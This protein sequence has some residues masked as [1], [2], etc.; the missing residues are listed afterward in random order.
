[1]ANSIKNQ[2]H[3]CSRRERLAFGFGGK[4][5]NQEAEEINHRDDAYGQTKTAQSGDQV[6]GHKRTHGSQQAT[7]VEAEPGAGCAN[8]GGIQ[9][10]QVNRETAENAVVEKS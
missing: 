4:W 6:T 8:P 9:F 3:S 5:Q 10:R 1:M 7:D 2:P